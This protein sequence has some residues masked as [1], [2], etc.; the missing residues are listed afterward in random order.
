[1][2]LSPDIECF[3]CFRRG[4]KDFVKKAGL[5]DNE[6][7]TFISLVEKYLKLGCTPP[8]AGSE[9]WKLL[10]KIS[11]NGN[12]IFLNEKIYFTKQ[13]L[14]HYLVLRN[15]FLATDSPEL[16]ALTAATWCNLIDVGQGN[17]LPQ[18]DELLKTLSA[19]LAL[20]ERI[21][22][23]NS[24]KKANTLLVIGDNAGETVMD[25]LFL[26]LTSFQGKKYYMTR[27]LPVMNDALIED[28]E[29]AGLNKVAE[30]ISSGI[31][32]PAVIPDMLYGK[33]KEVF[34]SADVILAKGQGNFEGLWGLDDT[35]I[36]HSFV[37]KCPVVSRATAIPMGGGVFSRFINTGG[38]N[39]NL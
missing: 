25:R 5:S 32:I 37:V 7:N 9:S 19:P 11:L 27:D 20:D 16:P 3:S 38:T 8:L 1:M 29:M 22:F 18:A 6:F 39:A 13:M 33:A 31:D 23:L 36:F 30:L 35:R 10:R 15:L 14:N 28:A 2:A 17:P 21:I 4:F 12:D 26:D 24:L 34:E